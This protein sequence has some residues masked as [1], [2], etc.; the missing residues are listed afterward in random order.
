VIRERVE[1]EPGG[2]KRRQSS[3]GLAYTAV[4]AHSIVTF[5]SIVASAFLAPPFFFLL[6]KFSMSDIDVDLG[7]LV[8][9]EQQLS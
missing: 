8:D 9:L 4:E 7:D 5:Y 1:R 6:A 3:R 2:T